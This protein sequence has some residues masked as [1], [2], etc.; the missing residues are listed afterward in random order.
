MD[1]NDKV[2][3]QKC[4]R[5]DIGKQW[6]RVQ[7]KTLK[8]NFIDMPLGGVRVEF[9]AVTNR[10]TEHWFA[11][12]MK[13]KC[14]RSDRAVDDNHDATTNFGNRKSF[15]SKFNSNNFYS[16]HDNI[17]ADDFQRKFANVNANTASRGDGGI[18]RNNKIK[19]NVKNNG[20]SFSHGG[21]SKTQYNENDH[22]YNGQRVAHF[23]KDN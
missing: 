17:E 23:H 10:Q 2:L 1:E 6:K 20:R 15:D 22:T 18:T 8:T 14:K 16:Q 13:V 9:E 5:N 4:Q 11:D 7:K 3:Q 21:K 19:E 12:N